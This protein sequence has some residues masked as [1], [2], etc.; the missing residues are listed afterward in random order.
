MMESAAPIYCPR[1]SFQSRLV[2]QFYLFAPAIGVSAGL[3]LAL[4]L[5]LIPLYAF[6][7]IYGGAGYTTPARVLGCVV[8]ELPPEVAQFSAELTSPLHANALR[9]QRAGN[10]AKAIETAEAALYVDMETLPASHPWL[11]ADW[12][13]FDKYV[14]D[15]TT[16]ER[17]AH[18]KKVAD[19]ALAHDL[20]D[21][22]SHHVATGRLVNSYLSAGMISEASALTKRSYRML[23]RVDCDATCRSYTEQELASYNRV[24]GNE[25]EAA[26]HISSAIAFAKMSADKRCLAEAYMSQAGFALERGEFTSAQKYAHEAIGLYGGTSADSNVIWAQLTEIEACIGSNKLADAEQL[27]EKL[28]PSDLADPCSWITP[29]YMHVRAQ[30]RLKR[31]DARG[32]LALME[33]CLAATKTRQSHPY[34]AEYYLT[35]ADVYAANHCPFDEALAVQKANHLELTR[36]LGTENRLYR[37]LSRR[38][39]S[40]LEKGLNN[41]V[42]EIG[43]AVDDSRKTQVL[44]LNPGLRNLSES[45]SEFL[46]A[47]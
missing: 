14:A 32:A 16:E 35:L 10:A 39:S 4:V 20:A 12:E 8:A 44:L 17:I 3:L 37:R 43:Y 15:M 7:T 31:G 25:R 6:A 29:K 19:F 13:M 26:I 34:M 38:F 9:Y 28:N 24:E 41:G 45:K 30:L 21:G 23:L 40:L 11:K 1:I 47:R 36:H 42:A 2:D 5:S 18:Q 22:H 46:L 33:V 27:M